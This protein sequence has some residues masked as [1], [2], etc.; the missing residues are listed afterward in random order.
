MEK[1]FYKIFEDLHKIFFKI[2]QISLI[3]LTLNLQYIKTLIWHP[4][5]AFDIV[6]ESTDVNTGT[7]FQQ[8]KHMA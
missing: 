5:S 8:K 6:W 1:R 7:F 3:I 4:E 2:L